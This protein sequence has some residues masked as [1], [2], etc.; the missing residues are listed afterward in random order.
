M[1]NL[2]S[3]LHIKRTCW[4]NYSGSYFAPVT[5]SGNIRW[6]CI[7]WLWSLQL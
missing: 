5:C 1:I 7:K 2:K 3:I 6:T 4:F